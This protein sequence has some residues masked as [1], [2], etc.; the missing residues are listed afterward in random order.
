MSN[1][2]SVRG[3][4]AAPLA[5]LGRVGISTASYL[6][7]LGFL[8]AGSSITL[9]P[10]GRTSTS[11]CRG[12]VGELSWMLGMGIPL[13]CLM[14]MGLGSFLAMQAYYGGTFVDGTGAVVGVGLFRNIAPLMS[15]LTLAGLLGAR[16]TPELRMRNQRSNSGPLDPLSEHRIPAK[17]AAAMITGPVVGLFGACVGTVVG[18]RVAVGLMGI[19]SHSFFLM[20]WDMLWLRDILGL[21]AKG[22]AF[23]LVSAAFACHEGLR[24]SADDSPGTTPDAA[25]RAVCFAAL[26]IMML[27]GS[28]FVLVYHAGPAFGPTLLKAPSA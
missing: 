15:G 7:G 23:G 13:S 6:G 20:F 18:W 19:T 4:V 8:V 28:W 9:W 12:L 16:I 21:F 3:P 25:F 14:H 17:L 2:M 24:G 22:V 5:W 10:F 1:S 26:T 27:N 11:G